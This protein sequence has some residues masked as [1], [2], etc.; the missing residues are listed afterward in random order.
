MAD[1]HTATARKLKFIHITKNAGTSIEDLAA[2]SKHAGSSS[3]S[4]S[5]A[6]E[7][8]SPPLLWGRFDKDLKACCEIL[9]SGEAFWHLPP[10]FYDQRMLSSLQKEFDFFVSVRNPYHRILSEYYCEWGGPRCKTEDVEAFN[11]YLLDRL[12]DVQ[13]LMEAGLRVDGHFAPQHVYLFN[14]KG[15]RIVPEKNVIRFE[16]LSD[17]FD[18][19]MRNYGLH[20]HACDLPKSNVS[21]VSRKFG[22]F[23]LSKRAVKMIQRVYKKDFELFGYPTEPPPTMKPET[24]VVSIRHRIVAHFIGGTG[25]QPAQPAQHSSKTEGPDS[26]DASRGGAGAPPIETRKNPRVESCSPSEEVS[27]PG[28]MYFYPG[29]VTT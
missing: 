20:L 9:K 28:S 8:V 16:S 12:Q 4:N 11:R 1:E 18:G 13:D 21:I 7:D 15:E 19:L 10:K 29:T 22:V 5:S 25:G 23:D 3:N 17:D 14:A 27:Y 2:R 6:C 24:D 26:V